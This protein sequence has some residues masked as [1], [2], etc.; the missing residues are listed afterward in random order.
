M[1]LDTANS[2]DERAF[3]RASQILGHL[4]P[5]EP[6]QQPAW[7]QTI[8]DQIPKKLYKAPPKPGKGWWT[9]GLIPDLKIDWKKITLKHSPGFI[10]E[11]FKWWCLAG[12]VMQMPGVAIVASY[13]QSKKGVQG[14]YVCES[15]GAFKQKIEEISRTPGNIRASLIVPAPGD[16][17]IGGYVVLA[18][19]KI[20]VC[21]E[22]SDSS[23]KIVIFDALGPP[24]TSLFN[25]FA[26]LDPSK[27][28][29]YLASKKMQNASY[30]CETFALR[31]GISFLQHPE[32]FE[33]IQT[34]PLSV[35]HDGKE[36]TF[37][38]IDMLPPSFMEMA[39]S[40]KLLKQYEDEYPKL[41]TEPAFGVVPVE[42]LKRH[43]AKY[44]FPF[45]EVLINHFPTRKFLKYHLFVLKVLETMKTED[46]RKIMSKTLVTASVAAPSNQG[47]GLG[48]ITRWFGR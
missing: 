5:P 32:F 15:L 28:K 46:I 34:R 9:E 17:V 43:V 33:R 30:G 41:V 18:G 26:Q 19:H 45:E 23:L 37:E 6:V 3:D 1:T 8:T 47:W 27:T 24:I 39:Q 2:I 35:L 13:L 11:F 22:K 10:S 12:P 38:Y 42:D 40:L 21:V 48:L 20:V 7:Y 36:M 31:A 44:T 25:C 29:V 16:T 14:L 4:M